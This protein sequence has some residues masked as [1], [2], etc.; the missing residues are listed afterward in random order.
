MIYNAAATGL[1][2]PEWMYDRFM[3]VLEPELTSARLPYLDQEY[4]NETEEQHQ[5]RM[6]RYAK[7]FH[8]FSEMLQQFG[9]YL[10]TQA[11][12][13]QQSRHAQRS[14]KEEGERAWQLRMADE[15]FGSDV[16]QTSSTDQ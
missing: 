4:A 8:T 12:D 16:S 6:H 11:R 14:L 3:S 10:Y 1:P 9:S 5:Q 7:A 13:L 2:P 15:L